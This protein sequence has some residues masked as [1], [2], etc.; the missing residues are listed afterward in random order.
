MRIFVK[1][2]FIKKCA[3]KHLFVFVLF[4]V[5]LRGG[6]SQSLYIEAFASGGWNVSYGTTSEHV[7]QLPFLTW[8]GQGNIGY[9]FAGGFGIEA[10]MTH[11]PIGI[12]RVFAIKN[13]QPKKEQAWNKRSTSTTYA[14]MPHLFAWYE[15]NGKKHFPVSQIG[16]GVLYAEFDIEL[17]FGGTREVLLPDGQVLYTRTLSRTNPTSPFLGLEGRWDI[18]LF[19]RPMHDL[20]AVVH[21]VKGINPIRYTNY[22]Y[23]IGNTSYDQVSEWTTY[24]DYF[25]LGISYKFKWP[26]HREKLSPLS[27]SNSR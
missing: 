18:R 16:F 22:D 27:R 1:S 12:T 4:S 9:A 19:H 5:F 7:R 11:F 2:L 8:F 6:F 17:L 10:G 3:M 14:Y 26:L 24:G 13:G 15:I 21:L 25:G 23:S 20:Y